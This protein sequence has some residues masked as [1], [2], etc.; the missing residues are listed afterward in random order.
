MRMS[1]RLG[2]SHCSLRARPKPR[3]RAP[4]RCRAVVSSSAASCMPR[5]TC[6][7]RSGRSRSARSPPVPRSSSHSWRRQP[8]S[9]PC[10][11]TGAS[12]GRRRVRA[13]RR[14][15]TESARPALP[16]KRPLFVERLAV[17]EPPRSLAAVARRVLLLDEQ[18]LREAPDADPARRLA[19]RC[20]V[21][22]R[23]VEPRRSCT[24]VISVELARQ[25]RVDD[26][27][28]V[29]R[30]SATSRGRRRSPECRGR[31]ISA[32]GPQVVITWL[33]RT[34]P[35]ALRAHG[36]PPPSRRSDP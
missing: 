18:P 36:R 20:G 21:G 33:R 24:P 2:S 28:E 25:P 31:S 3:P 13:G 30:P 10:A 12:R 23:R 22:R 11:R 16:S 7:T 4:A 35:C 8:S 6:R 27:L 19:R 9:V 17:H 1:S 5:A 32:P 29:V 34:C 14:A 26:L 15:R